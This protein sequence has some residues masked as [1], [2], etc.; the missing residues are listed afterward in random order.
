MK[1][2]IL[3]PLMTAAL[4]TGCSRSGKQVWHDTKTAAKQI[5]KGFKTLWGTKDAPQHYAAQNDFF[6]TVDEE[7]SIIDEAE[8]GITVE[9]IP[10]PQISPGDQ[11][12]PIPGIESFVQPAGSLSAIFKNIHFDCASNKIIGSQNTSALKKIASYMK[13]HKNTYLFVE[14]HCD[15]RGAADYNLALGTRRANAVREYLVKMGVNPEH[16][17]STSYGWERPLTREHNESAWKVNR[18][19]EFKL[20]TR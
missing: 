1:K 7:Y 13:E 8:E 2:A 16:L 19:T 20:Y 14:G 4:F 10:Q 18:R 6:S 17:F 9:S 5:G 3:L 11:G 15:E 12:A